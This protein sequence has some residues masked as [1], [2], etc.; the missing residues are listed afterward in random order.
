[1]DSEAKFE[2]MKMQA[3]VWYNYLSF[4]Y[5]DMP[6]GA[7]PLAEAPILVALAETAIGNAAGASTRLLANDW[8]REKHALMFQ[9]AR[10]WLG[11]D[12]ER[13]NRTYAVGMACEGHDRASGEDLLIVQFKMLDGSATIVAIGKIERGEDGTKIVNIDTAGN[14]WDVALLDT[15]IQT[16]NAENHDTDFNAGIVARLEAIL[17][18]E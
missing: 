16:Y 3:G 15:F 9:A 4:A 1:M 2:K 6:H 11:A 10:Q 8:A 12:R 13:G 17:A 5:D 14:T 7:M 18:K